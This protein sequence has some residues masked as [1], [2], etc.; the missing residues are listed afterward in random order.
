MEEDVIAYVIVEIPA[1]VVIAVMIVPL[2]TFRLAEFAAPTTVTE[3]FGVGMLPETMRK[4]TVAV[5]VTAESD[6]M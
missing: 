3:E 1:S 4:V 6:T 2:V 5:V